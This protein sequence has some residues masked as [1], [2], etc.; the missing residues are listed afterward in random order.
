[1]KPAIYG[2]RAFIPVTASANLV[3]PIVTPWTVRLGLEKIPNRGQAELG[4]CVDMISRPKLS[5]AQPRFGRGGGVA[6]G[7]GTLCAIPRRCPSSC[8]S[9][10]LSVAQVPLTTA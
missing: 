6:P 4:H 9:L 10:S 3:F 1:V 5:T 7:N 8:P 2:A